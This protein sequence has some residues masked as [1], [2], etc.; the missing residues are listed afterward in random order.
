MRAVINT[1]KIQKDEVYMLL[2]M[3]L[4]A[5]KSKRLLR[6]SLFGF[7]APV[8]C[9]VRAISVTVHGRKLSRLLPP[10]LTVLPPPWKN[11]SKDV[12]G[13]AWFLPFGFYEFSRV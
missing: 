7:G 4:E 11:P 9:F 6:L 2:L 10:T 13:G 3:N 5:Q 8:R 12:G 1:H